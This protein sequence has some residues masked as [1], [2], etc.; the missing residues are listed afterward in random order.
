MTWDLLEE[1]VDGCN[2]T[3]MLCTK[4]AEIYSMRVIEYEKMMSLNQGNCI[5]AIDYAMS[6]VR[7]YIWFGD[8]NEVRK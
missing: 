6:F 7:D 4:A 8:E 5:S 1:V 3:G 2:M